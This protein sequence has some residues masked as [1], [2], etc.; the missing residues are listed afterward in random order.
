MDKS[1]RVG[2]GK[3]GADVSGNPHQHRQAERA[4]QQSFGQRLASQQRHHHIDDSVRFAGGQNRNDRIV[5]DRR[6]CLRFPQE[7]FSM[8][9][10]AGQFGSHDLHRDPALQSFVQCLANHSHS[11]PPQYAEGPEMIQPKWHRR[12]RL[13]SL[14]FIQGMIELSAP[15]DGTHVGRH[16]RW[17]GRQRLELLNQRIVIAHFLDGPDGGGIAFYPL[18]HLDLLLGRGQSGGKATNR[19]VDRS[20]HQVHINRFGPT[21]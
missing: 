16:Q 1:G 9:G 14:R 13:G 15:D 21:S 7:S 19:F 17:L 5:F 20:F 10:T 4:S 2:C 8:F 11:A 12:H 3:T 6:D 18:R